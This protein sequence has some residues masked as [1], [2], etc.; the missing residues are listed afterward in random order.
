M[1]FSRYTVIS[2]LLLVSIAA[3]YRAIPGRPWGFAPQFAMAIFGGAMIK[4]KKLAIIMPLLSLL[5]SDLLY[6]LLYLNGL[7]EIKGFYTG[8][9]MNYLIFGSLT[10]VG[11]L[12][13]GEKIASIAKGALAAPTIFFL[14]SNLATW[15]GN[16][17]FQRP[18]TLSGLMQAYIDGIPFYANSLVAT[19]VFGAVL[20]GGHYM[21]SKWSGSGQVA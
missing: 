9:W 10:I 16:G 12:I 17:G 20:F 15:A 11:F 19:F 1:K 2:M 14:V 4:D 21:I 8:M 13:N 5:L 7:T 3:I 18:K 6:E